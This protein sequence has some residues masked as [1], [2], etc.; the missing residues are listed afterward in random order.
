MLS[1]F[2]WPVNSMF[3]EFMFVFGR[4]GGRPPF[5]RGRP[6]E[7]WDGDRPR[8]LTAREGVSST[9]NSGG[10]V[11]YSFTN[12]S[13]SAGETLD[14]Y[15]SYQSHR[16]LDF[17]VVGQPVSQPAPLAALE[18]VEKRPPA[19][20]LAQRGGPGAPSASAG[21][22]PLARRVTPPHGT[23][24]LLCTLL[25]LGRRRSPAPPTAHLTLSFE[26]S[27]GPGPS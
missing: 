2:A 27:N 11:T 23:R 17:T 26:S 25:G 16:E 24:H 22:G 15:F 13:L 12:V 1:A 19:A 14:A 7:T 20:D 3:F 8:L 6:F 9:F 21:R 10:T 18:R 4:F 5:P